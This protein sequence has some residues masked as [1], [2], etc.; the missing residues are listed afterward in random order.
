VIRVCEL[1]I[2]DKII[3]V[4]YYIDSREKIVQAD[5]YIIAFSAL[6]LPRLLFTNMYRKQI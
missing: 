5:G 2:H 1:S 4:K 6:H 3:E